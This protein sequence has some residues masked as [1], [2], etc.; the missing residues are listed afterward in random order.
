[1]VHESERLVSGL[2]EASGVRLSWVEISQ[3][4]LKI[5]YI[6]I[7]IYIKTTSLCFHPTDPVPCANA[8]K[9]TNEY[10]RL[11]QLYGVSKIDPQKAS[12]R[13][14]TIYHLMTNSLQRA[15]HKQ[16]E[17]FKWR[18]ARLRHAPSVHHYIV[19]QGLAMTHERFVLS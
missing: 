8:S 17:A 11:R 14:H 1:M 13:A 18:L 19:L 3:E 9:R 15:A 7:Y 12:S 5:V 6:Y 2:S 10:T 16:G 4:S